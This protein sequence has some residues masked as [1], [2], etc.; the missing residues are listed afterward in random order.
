MSACEKERLLRENEI[1]DI[2]KTK[3]KKKKRGILL[4]LETP[5]RVVGEK[6]FSFCFTLLAILSFFFTLSLVIL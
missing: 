1:G 5:P 6:K 4:F 2:G 3:K